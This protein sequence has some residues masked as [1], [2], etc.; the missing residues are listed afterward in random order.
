VVKDVFFQSVYAGMVSSVVY[1]LVEMSAIKMGLQHTAVWEAAAGMFLPIDQV[2]TQLGT[3]IGLIGHLAIGGF[4]G[5]IFYIALIY[6]GIDRS[7]LKGMLLGFYFWGFGTIM[8]RFGITS[9]VYFDSKEQLGALFGTV[10]FGIF[11][12]LLVPRMAM[13][14]V[15]ESNSIF[16][17]LL[18]NMVASPAYKHSRDYDNNEITDK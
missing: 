8:M 11:L 12:G 9:Y 7:V 4:W 2:G 3:I 16:R 10:I 13:K 18:V 17:G 1:A 6:I 14:N 15:S 5:I